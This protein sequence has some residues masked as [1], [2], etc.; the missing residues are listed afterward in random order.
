MRGRVHTARIA[1]TFDSQSFLQTLQL[2]VKQ[3]QVIDEEREYLIQRAPNAIEWITSARYANQPSLYRHWGAY[4]LVKEFFE[5]RCPIC[6][7]PKV[8]GPG[9]VPADSWGLSRDVLESEVLLR[10]DESTADD[11]CPKCRTTRSEFTEDGL[12]NSHRV[13]HAIVGQRAGKSSTLALV[14]TYIEHV[15]LTI[16]H[17]YP[18]GL[19]GYLGM[20]Q[21]EPLHMSFV[22]STGTQSQETIWAKYRGY[23][24]LAPWFKRYVPWVKM[25]EKMQETPIGMQRWEYAEHVRSVQNGLISFS[26]DSLTSNSHGLAGRTRIAAMIDEICRM[27]QTDG[28]SSAQ[29][30][31]RTMDASCQT[32]QE[33]ATRF[34]LVPWFGMIG[35]ISSPFSLDDYGMQLLDAARQDKRMYAVRLPTWEFN[36]WLPKARFEGMLR[37]DYVGTMR[38]FGAEPPGAA[39][40][41]IDRPDDFRRS[42]VDPALTPTASFSQYEFQDAAGRQFVGVTL[43]E[44]KLILKGAPRYIA[45]DAGANFDAFSLACAH[46]EPD[47]QGNFVTVFDW[48]I[49]ILTR[50][51]KQEVYFESIY[52]L[53]ESLMPRMVIKQVE[54]DHWN[55]KSIVQRIRNELQ[56]RAEEVATTN[57]HFIQFMRDAYSG[58]VRMLPE[59]EEDARLDPP[60]KSAQGAAIYEILKLER[61][62][63]TDKIYNA[64]KGVRRGWDSDDTARVIVHAHRLVQ[65][66]GYVESPDSLSKRDRRLRSEH[67][68]AEWTSQHRGQIFKPQGGGM[69]FIPTG[70]R[71]W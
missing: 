31:Y 19:Q 69:P 32:V 49:R 57:D 8:A 39:H 54:F 24:A 62:P 52:A 13:L 21:G 12:F 23:R 10:W 30:V 43:D 33:C 40:P 63:R 26:A 34:G 14:G 70:N 48:V 65:E 71:R 58:H 55:S 35:S 15:I 61:D 36:P 50:S 16:A 53:L 28:G 41:Y 2:S 38:N 6:N 11:V 9:S 25:Q 46:A 27:K 67:G 66:Q 59:T 47:E 60:F 37:K 64:R 7:D 22:A 42:A 29:E 17:S 5:L 3:S 68:L 1:E 56:I 51:K 20:P 45:A 4:R 44:A 18:G